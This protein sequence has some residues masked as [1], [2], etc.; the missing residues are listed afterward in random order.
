MTS[1]EKDKMFELTRINGNYHV[2]YTFTPIDKNSCEFEYYEWVDKDEL[3][4]TFSQEVLEKLK[5]AIEQESN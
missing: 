5:R 1:F 4:E 2:R 3:D